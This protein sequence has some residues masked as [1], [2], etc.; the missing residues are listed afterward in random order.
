M[1]L[2]SSQLR[3]TSILI[4]LVA[5][6]AAGQQSA[7]ERLGCGACHTAAGSAEHVRNVA[8]PLGGGTAA[9]YEP[10]HLFDYLRDPAPER[11][12]A[13]AP[14]MPDFRLDE[15]ERLALTLFLSGGNGGR[16]AR[17]RRARRTHP[18]IDRALGARIFVALNCAGCHEYPRAPVW[19]NAPPLGGLGNRLR[20]EWVRRYLARPHGV[21]P[22]GFYAGSGSRMPDFR[23][24]ES[25]ITALMRELGYGGAAGALA[26]PPTADGGGGDALQ[27][28]Q[29][30][31]TR[32]L[33]QERLPC[34]GCH[35]IDGVGGRIG[36]DLAGVASRLTGDYLERIVREPRRA[37][38]GTVMPAADLPE[39]VRQRLIAYLRSLAQPAAA[40]GDLSLAET[41]ILLPR[42][43]DT[44]AGSYRRQC[45]PCHGATGQGNGYNAPY[46]PVPPTRHADADHMATRPDDTL[47]DGIHGGGRI[48]G[49]SARMPDFGHSLSAAHIRT[50]VAY[51]RVL[52][53]CEQPAWA[54]R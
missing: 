28:W 44:A 2:R 7:L 32:T 38:L 42:R 34:L 31:D 15:R 35:A 30:H 11:A 12:A 45:A 20:P 5:G 10:D 36:P 16:D 26:A 4:T 33:L 52:C 54:R 47:F 17:V 23:L 48:L 43:T 39:S 37:M 18:D 50:L 14:R 41:P 3:L 9:R 1:P 19:R 21:R 8:P 24:T 49:R 40:S 22:F 29:L 27:P 53:D 13:G 6:P 25:E 51:L 46:L